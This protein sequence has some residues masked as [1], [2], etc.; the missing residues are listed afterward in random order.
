[1]EMPIN[2]EVVSA[3]ERIPTDAD[4]V[5]KKV[6]EWEKAGDI[7][8]LATVNMLLMGKLLSTEF[9]VEKL[10]IEMRLLRESLDDVHKVT[11]TKLAHKLQLNPE[12]REG[13]SRLTTKDGDVILL[14]LG[15]DKK[16]DLYEG[17]DQLHYKLRDVY[18]FKEIDYKT[19]NNALL[20]SFNWSQEEVKRWDDAEIA[21]AV[22]SKAEFLYTQHRNKKIT[23]PEIK[24]ELPYKLDSKVVK[25]ILLNAGW[26]IVKQGSCKTLFFTQPEVFNG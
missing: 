12:F 7:A 13:F 21:M 8:Q 20:K 26:V 19:L 5:Y 22:L 17:Y 23:I 25:E 3:L 6:S 10:T 11:T 4:L 9:S 15:S 1:M 24:K 16:C 2:A 18:G 14:Y